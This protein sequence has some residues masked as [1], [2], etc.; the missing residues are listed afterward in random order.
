MFS[1]LSKLA[2]DAVKDV[3]RAVD[4]G[5]NSLAE[6][7]KAQREAA[8]V[9]DKLFYD[10]LKNVPLSFPLAEVEF[11]ALLQ[12]VST[13]VPAERE[14]L[15]KAVGLNGRGFVVSQVIRLVKCDAIPINSVGAAV[16]AWP[17]TADQANWF[18]VEAA[19]DVPASRQWC[20]ER[21]AAASFVPVVQQQ[22][23][24]PM[25]QA[26]QMTMSQQAPQMTMSQQAPSVQMPSVGAPTMQ[27]GAPTMQMGAAPPMQMGAA[28][29]ISQPQPPQQMSVSVQPQAPPTVQVTVASPPMQ[30]A[31]LEQ[32]VAQLEATVA[33]LLAELNLQRLAAGFNA[34][35]AAA[36]AAAAAQAQAQVQVAAAAAAQAQAV[37]QVAQMAA[38]QNQVAASQMAAAQ[39]AQQIA[40][41]NQANILAQQAQINQTNQIAAANAAAHNAAVMQR[42]VA[43]ANTVLATEVALAGAVMA[44]EAAAM[45]A[46]AGMGAFGQPQI[47]VQ[48]SSFS[49]DFGASGFNQG[50]SVT[51]TESFNFN[52]GSV[53]QTETFTETSSTSFGF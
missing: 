27:M 39:A 48:T 7:N 21:I 42:D 38:A 20:Q 25:Q 18:Q 13:A 30:T 24:M 16:W 35:A 53:T 22:Q 49:N 28:P 29:A 8:K 50:V 2:T 10:Q 11:A 6:Q 34:N 26:P 3:S 33:A 46:L 41:Q 12:Q 43:I 4:S 17:R 15:I 51:Q 47:D 36:A 9:A 19:F 45:G 37:N 14:R 31:S 23:G 32:R 5:I 1:K 52:G 44:N 40:A